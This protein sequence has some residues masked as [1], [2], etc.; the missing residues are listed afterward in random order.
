MRF[1]SFSLGL[2]SILDSAAEAFTPARE[3][4]AAWVGG[5]R[6]APASPCPACGIA[7]KIT[8]T[9]TRRCSPEDAPVACVDVLDGVD[10]D[11]EG[12]LDE[13]GEL[14]EQSEMDGSPQEIVEFFAS[15]S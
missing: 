3:R 1:T 13:E 2:L 14:L 10:P 9:S 11:F 6:W 15:P 7:R 4:R 12:G 8:A 5:T